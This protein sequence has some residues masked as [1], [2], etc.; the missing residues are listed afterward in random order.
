MKL[1][2]SA[3]SGTLHVTATGKFSLQAAKRTF[4][5]MMNAVAKHQVAKVFFDG[6]SVKGKPEVIERF[7]F[8][9]FAANTVIRYSARGPC[10]S[11]AFA[12]VL[13][14]PL[15]DPGRFGENVAVNRGMNVRVFDNVKDAQRWLGIAPTKEDA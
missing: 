5:E 10:P 11:T 13:K 6:R 15:L 1:Q 12:Y 2:I 4:V 9:E 14:E 8:G 7:Y 3:D